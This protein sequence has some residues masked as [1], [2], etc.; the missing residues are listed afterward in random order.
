MR[1]I[2]LAM[3]AAAGMLTAVLAGADAQDAKMALCS[4]RPDSVYYFAAETIAQSLREP[5]L[6][7]EVIETSGSVD[8]LKR[9]ARGECDAA[10]AQRNALMV[11]ASAN[12]SRR[13]KV[14]VPIDLYEE[15]LHLI[16]RRESGIDDVGDLLGNPERQAL[17]GHA[18]GGRLAEISLAWDPGR[19]LRAADPDAGAAVLLGLP[20][21][22]YTQAFT[23]APNAGERDE[24]RNGGW[25]RK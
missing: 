19:L 3:L 9:M 20:S 23:R 12:V 11:F 18:E 1:H 10:M 4:A 8:N 15:L 7:V 2:A 21:L 5:G 16:C 13:L 14:A 24:S 22:P 17:H 25:V 6:E